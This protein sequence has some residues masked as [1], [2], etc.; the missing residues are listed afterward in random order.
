MLGAVAY[1]PPHYC[2][3]TVNGIRV[4][5]IMYDYL[6]CLIYTKKFQYRKRYKGAC[7][8]A[9]FNPIEI[10]GTSFNTVNGIRVHAIIQK[11][12]GDVYEQLVSIP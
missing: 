11:K 6:H 7:N 1:P 9:V 10:D 4:H 5:A 12:Y 8:V 3:N 2:F